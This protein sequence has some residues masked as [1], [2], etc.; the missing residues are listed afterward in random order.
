MPFFGENAEATEIV[1][2]FDRILEMT[3]I[4]GV[5]AARRVS[6][7]HFIE[8]FQGKIESTL[9][10]E[11]TGYTI[12]EVNDEQIQIPRYD[13]KELVQSAM[14]RSGIYEKQLSKAFEPPL[15]QLIGSIWTYW[16][17]LARVVADPSPDRWNANSN[18]ELNEFY[19]DILGKTYQMFISTWGK[20]IFSD[21]DQKRLT[22]YSMYI[23]QKVGNGDSF[24]KTSTD[25]LK[26]DAS[27]GD[28]L[29]LT[30]EQKVYIEKL[31]G[32]PLLNPELHHAELVERLDSTH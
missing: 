11:P 6:S 30:K 31:K 27:E 22:A 28:F 21:T 18:D 16:T 24:V 32:L 10:I 4:S 3:W 26:T 29:A 25:N 12:I 2:G 8:A 20:N 15:S 13:T 7:F 19:Q 23:K 17:L 9:L 1:E 14:L 5:K